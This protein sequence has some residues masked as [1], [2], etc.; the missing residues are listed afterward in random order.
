[1]RIIAQDLGGAIPGIGTMAIYGGFRTS[2]PM[3]AED[4]EGLPRGWNSLAVDRGFQK[5]QNVV[6][7]TP[8]SSEVNILWG[9]G[10]KEANEQTLRRT[11]FIMAAPNANLQIADRKNPDIATGVVLFPRGF[12]ASLASV[13]GY[14]KMDVKTFLWHHANI[15]WPQLVALGQTSW[16]RGAGTAEGQAT[17]ITPKPEQIMLV[18]AGGDQSGHGYWMQVGHSNY[19][20]V[21]KEIQ[22]PKHWDTLLQQALTDLGPLPLVH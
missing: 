5:D 17:P 12:V 11:A 14:A 9:F 20:N 13:S 18:V 4:E 7:A 8:V 22:L 16:A 15:S 2:Y 3:F 10:T 6:T 1:M 19:T 21:S